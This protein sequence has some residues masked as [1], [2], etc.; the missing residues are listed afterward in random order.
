MLLLPVVDHNP[1][2]NV[3]HNS[4]GDRGACHRGDHPRPHPLDDGRSIVGKPV[5]EDDGVCHQIAGDGADELR[6]GL[7]NGWRWRRKLGLLLLLHRLG[8]L[9]RCLIVADLTL[10]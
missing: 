9:D 10:H 2:H 6:R 7:G 8:E 5:R 3:G 4:I 1:Q